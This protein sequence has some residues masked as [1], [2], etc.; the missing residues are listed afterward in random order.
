VDQMESAGSLAPEHAQLMAQRKDLK[1]QV[2]RG[3]KDGNEQTEE[4]ESDCKHIGDDR[5]AHPT[6]LCFLRRVEF[7]TGTGNYIALLS[8]IFGGVRFIKVRSGTF[9]VPVVQAAD[10]ALIM[11]GRIFG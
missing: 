1:P 2:R 8:T 5:A 4:S 7:T 10:R 11:S 9:A 6:A 3:T